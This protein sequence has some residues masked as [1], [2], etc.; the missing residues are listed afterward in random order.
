LYSLG[1]FNLTNFG[2]N[3]TI[4]EEEDSFFAF[5]SFF[6]KNHNFF[7][8]FPA[9]SSKNI[10]SGNFFFHA[11][12]CGIEPTY[13]KFQV[14]P[15]KNIHFIDIQSFHRDPK[16]KPPEAIFPYVL[17]QNS[18]NRKMVAKSRKII[19]FR[20]NKKQ[21]SSFVYGNS[22]L[23]KYRVYMAYLGHC[24]HFYDKKGPKSRFSQ[25]FAQ[26]LKFFG[27]WA[28]VSRKKCCFQKNFFFSKFSDI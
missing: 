12:F 18:E 15:T 5:F 1:N 3:L 20:S 17:I 7:W 19:F 23:A 16:F 27:F 14:I 22:Y 21:S 24:Y 10:F 25:N 4:F 6:G 9:D 26:K 8:N 2:V 11:K 28:V 13:T